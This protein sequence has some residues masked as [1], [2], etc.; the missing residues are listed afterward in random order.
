MKGW[1]VLVVN[2]SYILFLT[3]DVI[4]ND[5]CSTYPKY[6]AFL[7]A[8]LIFISAQR[9]NNDDFILSLPVLHQEFQNWHVLFEHHHD[10][11]KLP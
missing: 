1:G 10:L 8:C 2:L 7:S 9:G 11:P 5:M 3:N 6:V 4:I